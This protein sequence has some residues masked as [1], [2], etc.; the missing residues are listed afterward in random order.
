MDI[1]QSIDWLLES[2]EIVGQ[3]FYRIFFERYPEVQRYFEGVRIERQA[4]VLSIAL[5]LVEQYETYRYPGIARY[6]RHLGEKHQLRGIPRELYSRFRE[7]MLEA[8]QQHH[9]SHWSEQLAQQWRVALDR[10]IA[11]M[12]EAYGEPSFVPVKPD[13]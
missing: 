7:A 2:D 10:A 11:V 4:V 9:E 8:L 3:V 5:L 1:H 6:L 13:L 12:L